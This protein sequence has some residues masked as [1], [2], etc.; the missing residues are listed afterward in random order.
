[1]ICLRYVRRH[2]LPPKS[3]S[4]INNRRGTSN[5]PSSNLSCLT[6]IKDQKEKLLR[7][8]SVSTVLFH[9]EFLNQTFNKLLRITGPMIQKTV[10]I[11][12][13]FRTLVEL[14]KGSRERNLSEL[15]PFRSRKLPNKTPNFPYH[16]DF[17]K[18]VKDR[19]LFTF[20]NTQKIKPIIIII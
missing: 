10:P 11:P 12:I 9:Y 3:F 16:K 17:T 20:R 18:Y 14:G 6:N 1:M 13:K 4:F 8:F 15:W 5:N 19:D 2:F 7:E